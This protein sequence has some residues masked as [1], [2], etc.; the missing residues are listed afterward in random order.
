MKAI[1][2]C[3]GCGFK[4]KSIPGPTNCIRCNHI[5]VKWGNYREWKE[6]NKGYDI[7][8]YKEEYKCL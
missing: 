2:L 8:P 4:W 3:L 7:Y 1:F 5:W 6:F